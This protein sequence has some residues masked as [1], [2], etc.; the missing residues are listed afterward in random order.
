MDTELTW[1]GEAVS[2]AILL[3]VGERV[4]AVAVPVEL[5]AART[6]ILELR[7]AHLE[8]VDVDK[9]VRGRR[10]V[11]LEGAHVFM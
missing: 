5:E 4:A 2:R 10:L 3:A 6:L 8:G 7:V 1:L 11:D 9:L